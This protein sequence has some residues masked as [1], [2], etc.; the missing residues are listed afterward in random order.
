MFKKS[1]YFVSLVALV[2]DILI[3]VTGLLA[4]VMEST[5]VD[6]V[7]LESR[8]YFLL[9]CR[10]REEDVDGQLLREDLLRM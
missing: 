3:D 2:M 8:D 5:S 9:S 10:H 6:E 4:L 7:K 1:T